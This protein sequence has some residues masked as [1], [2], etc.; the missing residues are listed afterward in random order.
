MKL[1]IRPLIMFWP[2]DWEYSD[3]WSGHYVTR[4]SPHWPS[5]ALDRDILPSAVILA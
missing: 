3:N 1:C 2:A 5:E 4:Y